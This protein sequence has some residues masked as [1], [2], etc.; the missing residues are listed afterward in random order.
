M[1]GSTQKEIDSVRAEGGK[2]HLDENDEID[3]SESE[4]PITG[5]SDNWW[6]GENQRMNYSKQQ[7]FHRE[8]ESFHTTLPLISLRPPYN[9]HHIRT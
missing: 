6:A 7:F 2:L 1:Y 3:Y 5:F 4:I 8:Y 9:A